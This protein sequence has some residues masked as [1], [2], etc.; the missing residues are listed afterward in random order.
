MGHKFAEIAFTESVRE[1][2]QAHGSRTGYTTMEA[3]EDR[4]HILNE[5]EAAFITARDSFYMASV[6][7]TGW[8]YVQH[9]GGPAGF[10]RVLDKRTIGFADFTGNRQYVSVGNVK[11]DNRVALIFMDYPNRTRLKLL[12]RVRLVGPQ[13]PSLLADLEV[14]DYRAR[15]ECGFL[16]HVEAFDWNCP[17]H[18]TP[19]YTDSH[20]DK[21]IAPLIE[22]IRQLKTRQAQAETAR[23][24][25]L[26]SGPLELIISGISQL[27]PRIRAYELRNPNGSTLPTIEPG[28]HLPVPIRLPDGEIT[29]RAYSI[30]S[31]PARHDVYEIAVLREDT[32]KGGSRALHEAFDIGLRLRCGLPRNHFRLHTDN[33]PAVLM[34][35][36]IGIT[37]IK[38]MA[39]ALKARGNLLHLHYAGH[40]G[41]EMAFR[42]RLQ[43]AFGDT[44][45]LYSSADGERMDIEKI[46]RDAPDE[47]VFY[48]CGPNRMIEA[49][50]GTAAALNIDSERIRFERFMATRLFDS[51]PIHLELRRSDKEILVHAD[52]SVLD[53]ML[54]AGIDAPYGC[55]NGI[56]KS[57]AVTVLEGEPEHRDSI[58]SAAERED[59]RLMCPCV[60]R[61][62]SDRL[63]LQI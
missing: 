20:I 57:C 60:S 19:R 47:A 35:G 27:T 45:T 16:I 37:P 62:K 29:T 41:P 34:A 55:R 25:V 40:S 5:R 42:D 18:I 33:R 58:L 56:C 4:N 22:E 30:C 39:H 54:E 32:G 44:L 12:G 23:P 63:A 15:V 28:S 21:L 43:R 38:A 46:L 61:A 3:G 10:V 49:V 50:T 52:Q 1:V 11:K 7:E 2:Q 26:G 14:A 51:R 53:A 48:V 13:E 6:S 9:R 8:P 24:R 17:Q 36:G 59:K 31:N